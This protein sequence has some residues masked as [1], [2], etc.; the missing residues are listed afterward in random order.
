MASVRMGKLPGVPI[1][2][3]DFIVRTPKE[4]TARKGLPLV[5]RNEGGLAG[6]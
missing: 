4:L 5:K 2:T 1:W 6:I 3:M